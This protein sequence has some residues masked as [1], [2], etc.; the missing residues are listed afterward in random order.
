MSSLYILDVSAL[1]HTGQHYAQYGDCSYYGYPTAGIRYLNKYL[2]NAL[3]RYDEVILA[4]DS[5]SFRNNLLDTYKSGRVKDQ[6]VI[7]Q[8][9]TVYEML[10]SCGLVCEKHDGYEADDIIEWAIADH[11]DNNSY[12]RLYIVGNDYDLCHSIRPNVEFMA[13]SSNVNSVNRTNFRTA[14]VE[15]VEI[16]FNTISAYKVFCGCH[17]DKIPCLELENGYKGKKLYDEFVGM[18]KIVKA[19]GWYATSCSKSLQFFAKNCGYFTESDMVELE[20]RIKLVYPAEK[21]EGLLIKPNKLSNCNRSRLMHYFSMFGDVKALSCFKEK[22]VTLTD[23]D[24]D[25]LRERGKMLSSG[26]YAVDNNLSPEL[27]D[28]IKGSCLTLDAFEREF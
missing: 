5:P 18:L 14:I 13:C 12:Y 15:G 7:S 23:S 8:I 22:K 24:K 28:A 3:C 20:R 2:C 17:S 25:Y 10:S 19:S 1:I 16:E 9:E 6:T 11:C 27:D 21:P 4:F 26:I